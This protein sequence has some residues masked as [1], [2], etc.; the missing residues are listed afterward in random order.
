MPLGLILDDDDDG[1]GGGR[2]RRLLQKVN[3]MSG[4]KEISYNVRENIKT[5]MN[6]S[7]CFKSIHVASAGVD[8]V[9]HQ[10]LEKNCSDDT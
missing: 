8:S 2:R 4:R 1:G 6:Y 7:K 3:D 9:T 10:M 5:N